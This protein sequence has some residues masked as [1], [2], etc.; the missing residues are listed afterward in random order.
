M[1]RCR[2]T[3][4]RPHVVAFD[5]TS[6]HR[7]ERKNL[8]RALRPRGPSA[9]ASLVEML[10]LPAGQR[11]CKQIRRLGF[12]IVTVYFFC[13]YFRHVA[14]VPEFCRLNMVP[15]SACF[16]HGRKQAS[17]SNKLFFTQSVAFKGTFPPIKYIKIATV[18]FVTLEIQNFEHAHAT[19]S[20]QFFLVLQESDHTTARRF[21]QL[22]TRELFAFSPGI[23]I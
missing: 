4:P 2:I 1:C 13:V 9:L 3:T 17:Y 10:C 7:V 22:Q 15:L 19:V 6:L 16:K 18:D 20:V 14:R 5:S 8:E 21:L 12:P 23:S 11:R